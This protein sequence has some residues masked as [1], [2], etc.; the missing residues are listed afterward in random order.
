MRAYRAALEERTRERVPLDWA[1]A[2][3][4]LK[5]RRCSEFAEARH[6][7]SLRWRRGRTRSR[8]GEAA[9]RAGGQR[10][11]PTPLRARYRRRRRSI[12]RLQKNCF[13]KIAFCTTV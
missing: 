2:T 5:T 12:A 9:L 4:N 7:G 13:E 3:G 6:F 8:S 10:R 11:S 1:S